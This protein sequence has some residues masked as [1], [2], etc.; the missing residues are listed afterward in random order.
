MQRITEMAKGWG[1]F[2]MKNE[3]LITSEVK[4]WEWGG[5]QNQGD[6][7]YPCRTDVPKPHCTRNKTCI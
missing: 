7:W 6:R 2:F 3:E 4:G 1:I 5:L